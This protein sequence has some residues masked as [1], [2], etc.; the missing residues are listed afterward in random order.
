MSSEE[1]EEEWIKLVSGKVVAEAPVLER[2][3][4][5]QVWCSTGVRGLIV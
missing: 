2:I 4:Q 1:L 5:G 3:G